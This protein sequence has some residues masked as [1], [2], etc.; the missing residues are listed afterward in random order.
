MTD[1]SNLEDTYEAPSIQPTGP[2]IPTYDAILSH[3]IVKFQEIYGT[4]IYLDNDSQDYQFLSSLALLF[5]DCCQTFLLAYNNQNPDTAISTALDRLCAINGITRNSNSYSYATVVLTGTYGANITY[6]QVQ[7]ANGYIWQL[8]QSI[9]LDEQDGEDPSIGHATTVATCLTPGSIQAAIGTINIIVNP[10]QGWTSVTNT[11]A[12]NPGFD[13]ETDSAL[14]ERRAQS[15]GITSVTSL[16]SLVAALSALRDEDDNT[17]VNRVVVYENDTN[18]DVEYENGVTDVTLTP[19]SIA[20]I[21]ECGEVDSIL[22]SIAETIYLKK[23]PGCSTVKCDSSSVGEYGVTRVIESSLG[24]ENTINFSRLELVEA[25]PVVINITCN[26]NYTSDIDDI[27]KQNVV[28]YLNGLDIGETLQVTNLY[29]PI[30]NANPNIS[31][32]S[33]YITSVTV[34]GSSTSVQTGAFKAMTCTAAN[35]TL[36]KTTES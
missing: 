35:I 10:Q 5:Y 31:A 9:D 1:Y 14:R 15:V 32:P 25:N 17:I 36:N 12:A 29:F 33:F 27:I 20:V 18:S 22:Q 6:G 19:H 13:V 21:C 16:D 24:L 34:N 7:D 4:D 2:V 23:T 28:E 30:L 26:T 8:Y 11:S 3:L